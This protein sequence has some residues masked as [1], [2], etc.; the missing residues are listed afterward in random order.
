MSA[1]VAKFIETPYNFED[2]ICRTKLQ[3]KTTIGTW[4]VAR[5]ER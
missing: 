2:L 3:G 4:K 5:E 1:R